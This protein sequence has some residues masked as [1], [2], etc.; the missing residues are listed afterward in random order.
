MPAHAETIP[1]D[2]Y[3]A[4]R[5]PLARSL[6]DVVRTAVESLGEVEMRVTKSQVAFWRSHPFAWAWIPRQYLHQDDL[7]PL[8]MSVDLRRRDES[9]RW[10]QVVEPRP[11]RFTHHLELY[12]ADQIDDEVRA[13]LREAWESAE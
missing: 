10:K 4:D 1:L 5:E 9:P 12:S 13:W 8:V 2:Q 11:G 7:A 3:F 6:F